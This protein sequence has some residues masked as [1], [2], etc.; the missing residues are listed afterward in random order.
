MEHIMDQSPHGVLIAVSQKRLLD[1]RVIINHSRIHLQNDLH[2][3]TH[4]LSVP[5]HTCVVFYI[6]NILIRKFRVHQKQ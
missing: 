2:T 1:F 4:R 5:K 3:F 6:T